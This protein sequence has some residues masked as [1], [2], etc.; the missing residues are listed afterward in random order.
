VPRHLLSSTHAFALVFAAALLV[1]EVI[2]QPSFI[3]PSNL[4]SELGTFAPFAILAMASTPSILSGGGGIDLSVGPLATMVN[5]MFV[6]WLLPHGWAAVPS[7]AVLLALG[8]ALGAING[9]LVAVARFQPVIATLCAFFVLSGLSE[10]IAPS[11][12]PAAENWTAHLANSVGFLPGAVLTIGF[13]VLVWLALGRTAYL[14]NLMAVGGD[15]AS[16]YSAGANVVAVR[17]GAYALGGLFAAV[18]GIAL[19]AQIETSSASLATQYA[20]I[21]LAGVALGGTSLAGGRGG[22]LGSLLGA[23]CIYLLQQLLSSAGV[24]A[25]YLQL[26]YGVLLV[27]GVVISSASRGRLRGAAA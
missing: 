1:A 9:T 25:N 26:V 15:D 19:T 22:I 2:A 10:K 27:A 14:R 12:N 21:A 24:A 11:P 17:I 4:P 20:L 3:D 18:A 8:A 6:T 23:A 16:A 5:C 7:V 13:P